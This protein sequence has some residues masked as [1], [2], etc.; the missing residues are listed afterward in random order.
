M[1][2][3]HSHDSSIDADTKHDATHSADNTSKGLDETEHYENRGR[4]E[5]VG[6]TPDDV[7]N[8]LQKLT[9]PQLMAEVDQFC[10][11]YGLQ[12]DNEVFRRGALAARNPKNIEGITEL[13]AEDRETLIYERN[14]PWHLPRLLFYSVILCAIG[15]ATQGWDQTGSNGANL[16]FP[17][18]FGI[19]AKVGEPNGERDEWIVGLVNSSV[20]ISAAFIGCWSKWSARGVAV[21][22]RFGLL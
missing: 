21:A 15:A 18:E 7:Y 11:E 1:S 6:V 17:Q 8:P 20:Y 14:H 2:N 5:S 4:R 10:T 9:T 13:S 22:V 19:G 16:S 12:E 3:P